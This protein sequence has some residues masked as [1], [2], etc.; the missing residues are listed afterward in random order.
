MSKRCSEYTRI[1]VNDEIYRCE[2]YDYP[3]S[4]CSE[5]LVRGKFKRDCFKPNGGLVFKKG[6]VTAFK[7]IGFAAMDVDAKK[8]QKNWNTDPEELENWEPFAEAYLA[9]KL[10]G[11]V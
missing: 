11:L 7:L 4:G 6:L 8:S 1:I 2:R 9:V 10:K 3:R 5:I